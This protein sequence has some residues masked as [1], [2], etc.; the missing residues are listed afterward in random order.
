MLP[1]SVAFT[2]AVLGEAL[3]VIEGIDGRLV[4]VDKTISFGSVGGPVGSI[5]RAVS[6]MS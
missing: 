6:W 5:I 2:A 3:V 1:V 4:F